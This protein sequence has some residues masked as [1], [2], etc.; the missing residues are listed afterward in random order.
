MQSKKLAGAKA[1]PSTKKFL[2]FN[3]VKEDVVV[4]KDGTLRAVLMVSSINFALKSEDEQNAIIQQY[5]SFMNALESPIQIVVQSRRLNIE[6]YLERLKLS[7]REQKNDLLRM[8][9]TD[10][11]AFVGE[12]IDLGQIMQKQFFVVVPY[13]PMSDKRKNFWTQMTEVLTPAL[14]VRLAEERFQQRKR[15]LM[16]RVNSTVANLSSMGLKAVMLN[17]Q[18]LIEL[19]YRAYNPELIDTEKLDD[20]ENMRVAENQAAP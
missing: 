11:R 1:G 19:Y 20:M 8:Q 17:T 3:E 7:E 13:N 9:I 16:N 12:L 15:D 18:Q 14:S 2:D 10:Y 4:M 6:D 5:I